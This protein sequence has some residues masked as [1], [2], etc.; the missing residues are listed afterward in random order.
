MEISGTP[1]TQS[2]LAQ[3]ENDLTEFSGV[4]LFFAEPNA[5]SEQRPVLASYQFLTFTGSTIIINSTD[6]Q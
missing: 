1:T 5:Q 4:F 6:E 2:T 3:K